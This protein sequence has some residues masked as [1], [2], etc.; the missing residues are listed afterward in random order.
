MATTNPSLKISLGSKV[1]GII[2]Y[3]AIILLSLCFA[4]P[5]FKLETLAIGVLL[6]VIYSLQAGKITYVSLSQDKFVIENIFRADI[7]KEGFLFDEIV[8][9]IPFT[10]LMKIKFKDG[11]SFFFWG[12]SDDELNHLIKKTLHT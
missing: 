12:R 7:E 1:I 6:V 5:Y 4:L 2:S 9:Q 10:H 11:S 8:E 3:I